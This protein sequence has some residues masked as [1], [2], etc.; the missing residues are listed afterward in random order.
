MRP[1]KNNNTV[2]AIIHVSDSGMQ[3]RDGETGIA[4]ALCPDTA[5][6]YLFQNQ[7]SGRSRGH[8]TGHRRLAYTPQSRAGQR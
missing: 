6:V 1:N 7:R 3:E 5:A 4:L 2:E 8:A